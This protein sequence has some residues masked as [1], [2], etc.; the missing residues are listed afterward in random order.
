MRRRGPGPGVSDG[1]PELLSAPCSPLPSACPTR[2]LVG[3]GAQQHRPLPWGCFV[4]FCSHCSWERGWMLV[5]GRGEEMIPGVLFLVWDHGMAWRYQGLLQGASG[6]A[7]SSPLDVIHPVSCNEQP[8]PMVHFQKQ[9]QGSLVQSPPVSISPVSRKS[10][11]STP[12]LDTFAAFYLPAT[13]ITLLHAG[14]G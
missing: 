9:P 8:K 4:Y 13:E 2:C 6:Q 12:G 5:A 10:I 11:S 7:G 3:G 14:D 1:F